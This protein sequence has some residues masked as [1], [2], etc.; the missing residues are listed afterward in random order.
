MVICSFTVR[1]CNDKLGVMK[2]GLK[3]TGIILGALLLFMVALAVI[4]PVAFREKIKE[5][6]ESGLNDML[7]AKVSFD[8]YKLNFL[9]SFPNASFLLD[10]LNVTGTGDFEGDTLASVK[11]FRIVINLKSLFA[12]SGYEIKS[13]VID[14]PVLNA[15]VNEDGKVNWEIMKASVPE[16]AGYESVPGE[17]LSEPVKQEP[18]AD[19]EEQSGLKLLLR[20][21][22][23]NN[24]RLTYTDHESDMMAAIDDLDFLLSGNMSGSAT[25]LDLELDAGSVDFVMDNVAW[26]TDATVSFI[27]EIDAQLDSMRFTLLDNVLKLN[28]I[29]LN[30]SGTTT[31]PGDDIAVDM[32]FSAPETSFKSL[33]SLIP[34]FYMKGYED[35]NASGNVTLDGAIKGIYSSADSTLPDVAV[36]LQVS[37]GMISYPALP[38]KIRDI[39]ISGKVQTDGTDMDRT[40]ADINRFHFV[41]AG[42]PFDLSLN[43]ATPLSDPAINAIAKGKIDLA[44]LRQAIPLD[45]M[46]LNGIL[47]I[48]LDLAGRMSMLE[49]KE[50]DQF[51][52]A[53]N[54]GISDMAVS[55]TDMPD[56]KISKAELVFNPAWAELATMKATMG[57]GSDFSISGKLENYIQYLFSDGTL[58]GNLAV[59]SEKVDLNEIMDILPADTV[60]TDTIPMEVIRIPED[61]DFA[62]DAL[63]GSLRYGFLSASDVKGN[64]LVHDGVVS[65]S[66]TGMKALGG[67]LLVNALYDTRD[68]LKPLVD[69]DML[70]S[71]VNIKETFEAF[72]T[73]RQLM[74]AAAGLGGNVSAEIDFS[75]IL[76]QGMMPMINTLSG[77]GEVRSESVQ[78]VESG[79]FDKIKSVLKIDPAYTN[80]VK[81][82]KATF[83]INDGRL[84]VKPFDVS[85]G[86]IRLNVSGD[87]GLDRTI[88]YLVK[89]EIPR[90]ELGEAAGALMSSFASQAAALG[91]VATPPEVI[92]INLNVGGTVRAPAIT[93]S[94]AGGSVT[95]V[96]EAVTDTIRQEVTDRVNEAARV[97]ADRILKEA[98]NNARILREE[99]TKSAEVIRSE[100]DLRGKKLVKDAEAHGPIAVAAARRAAEALNREADKRAMQL[101]T[102]ADSRADKLLAEAK[103]KADELLK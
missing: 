65:V 27:S 103:A 56:L 90:E 82:L 77:T 72:N 94:F 73:V 25:G 36:N 39:T 51:R 28:D 31:M 74:P 81:D 15:I 63:V 99:A 93:P 58:R 9:R 49:N 70:I 5:K 76:G 85:L 57:Q 11:S 84:F 66:E 2:K 24:G 45:S 41:L 34:A 4:I 37:D 44:G 23:I 92:K 55:M 69:A 12:D 33:L 91:F 54:L 68:T 98:D 100:A 53:G 79:C 88:N 43:I 14:D 101:V 40:V 71:A 8:D 89:A 29:S 22:A 46:T 26:L 16:Q 30:F 61:I 67:S 50:Y 18:V 97:Q 20:R 86:K 1:T 96:A 47:D 19:I 62:L 87:Q 64:I 59:R 42:N 95:S 13:V 78:I 10:K 6:V 38:E 32:L 80:I 17:P 83:I 3:I 60:E 52:A 48:S 7:I 35:L 102:E 21:F 75:S